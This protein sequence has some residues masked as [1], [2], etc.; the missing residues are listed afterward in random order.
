MTREYIFQ[1]L[2]VEDPAIR[3]NY[4]QAFFTSFEQVT[5]NRLIHTLWNWEYGARRLATRVPYEDQIIFA[6]CDRAGKVEAAL[7]FNTAMRCFQSSAF[8]FKPPSETTGT[9]EVLTFF[10]PRNRELGIKFRLWAESVRALG[11]LGFHTGFATTASRPL[12]LYLRIGWRLAE[13]VELAAEKRFFLHYRV[14]GRL[15]KPYQLATVY[16][17][18]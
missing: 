10:N 13:E 6:M 9:F 4:E 17:Q 3:R 11:A 18:P 5:S 12:R 15:V 7:A 2:N 1:R 8:G 14:P 16:K